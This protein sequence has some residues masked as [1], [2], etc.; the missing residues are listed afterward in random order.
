MPTSDQSLPAGILSNPDD[1]IEE[2]VKEDKEDKAMVVEGWT[3][4]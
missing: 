2:E 4:E 3:I 1:K